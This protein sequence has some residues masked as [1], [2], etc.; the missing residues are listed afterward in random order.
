[1][2]GPDPARWTFALFAG[3]ILGGC[4]SSALA[5]LPAFETQLA[6]DDAR[7]GRIVALDDAGT[8]TPDA[9]V[10]ALVPA[11]FVLL[12]ER[13]DH[14][15]HHQLQAWLISA[16]VAR[17]RRPAVV[18]EMVHAGQREALEAALVSRE[19]DAIARA[20]AWEESGW[21]DFALYRPV[22]DAALAAGL[23]LVAGNAAPGRVHAIAMS[24]AD[25]AARML[26]D[27]AAPLSD[28][29][30]ARLA[31]EIERGHCG[32]AP[33][34]RIDAMLEAQRFRDATM[35]AALL[36]ADALSHDGAVLIAGTGHVA[37]DAGVPVQLAAR[38]PS[39]SVS[40]VA[41]LEVRESL[42]DL[43]HPASTS[44]A[45]RDPDALV[46]DVDHVWLTPRLDDREPCEKYRE[47]LER[48][49]RKHPAT[50]P[51][52]REGR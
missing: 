46:P 20:V 17:G 45:E 7:A 42:P 51:T 6:R 29:G 4:S 14:P 1:M 50:V 22:I 10:D 40:S 24:H 33:R 44:L 8:I 38:A 3:L 28:L 25:A 26:L 35:A 21:P 41:F 11:R 15:D 43:A 39:L 18:L 34:E 30:R 31:R 19:A 23:P 48:M 12:G 27:G 2:T 5:P 13:H 52:P 36:E 37:R 9:L 32:H 49:G 47:A 16:L